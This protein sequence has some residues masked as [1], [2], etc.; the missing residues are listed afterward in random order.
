MR[1]KRIIALIL[2]CVITVLTLAS[3]RYD[4]KLPDYSL[5]RDTR[6]VTDRDVTYVEISFKNYG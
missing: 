4:D 3:C 6:D 2:V 1:T 5:Y